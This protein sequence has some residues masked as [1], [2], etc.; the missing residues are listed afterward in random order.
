MFKERNII[1]DLIFFLALLYLISIVKKCC[2]NTYKIE[3]AKAL[4]ESK[5][6]LNKPIRK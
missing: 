3:K 4:L 5:G 6:N 1:R 2:I